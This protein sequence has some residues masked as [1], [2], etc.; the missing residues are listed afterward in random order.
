V[1]IK[2]HNCINSTSYEKQLLENLLPNLQTDFVIAVDNE[3]Y[4]NEKEKHIKTVELV[5]WVISF[6]NTP[7]LG[8]V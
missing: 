6:V 2:Y 5:K 8:D 7:F 4:R 1:D 3:T